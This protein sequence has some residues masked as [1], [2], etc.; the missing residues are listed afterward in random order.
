MIVVLGH[1]IQSQY[2]VITPAY[3]YLHTFYIIHI[4]FMVLTPELEVDRRFD[5]HLTRHQTRLLG[6]SFVSVIE[7]VITSQD[8]DVS[9]HVI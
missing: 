6:N 8:H 5:G 1:P 2:E 9:S 4:S 3:L 7:H